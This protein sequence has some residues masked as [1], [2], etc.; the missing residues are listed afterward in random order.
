MWLPSYFLISHGRPSYNIQFLKCLQVKIKK[1]KLSESAILISIIGK[2]LKHLLRKIQAD[3]YCS[4]TPAVPNPQ[5]HPCVFHTFKHANTRADFM[6][7]PVGFFRLASHSSAA[8]IRLE[9]EGLAQARSK[10]NHSTVEEHTLQNNKQN[11]RQ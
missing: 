6:H 11:R 2:C 4:I 9:T 5:I 1:T 3:A 8:P 7:F 10:Q